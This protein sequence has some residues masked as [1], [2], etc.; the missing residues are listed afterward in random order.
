MKTNVTQYTIYI[1]LNDPDTGDQKFDTEK[2]VSILKG[3][4]QKHRARSL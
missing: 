2:Y 3:V 4:L 1:G